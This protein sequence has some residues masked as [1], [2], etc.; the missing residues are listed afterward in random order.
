MKPETRNAP[1][2]SAYCHHLWPTHA[3]SR[4]TMFVKQ[5]L[6]WNKQSVTWSGQFRWYLVDSEHHTGGWLAGSANDVQNEL[7]S[8]SSAKDD[9]RGQVNSRVQIVRCSLNYCS[10]QD[11]KVCKKH[12]HSNN[13]NCQRLQSE[14]HEKFILLWDCLTFSFQQDNAPYLSFQSYSKRT[15][16]RLQKWY[17]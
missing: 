2:G 12:D 15:K 10:F 5:S 16:Q 17:P 13:D 3:P 7:D 11:D 9:K 14:K 8:G 4:A 1:R 6:R